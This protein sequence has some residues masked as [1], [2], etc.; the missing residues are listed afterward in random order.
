M[1]II[2][3]VQFGQDTFSKKL[4]EFFQYNHH[5]IAVYMML[6][7]A[8]QCITLKVLVEKDKNRVVFVES[9]KDFVD[10]LF[11]FMTMPIGNIIRLAREHSIEENFGCLNNL[12]ESVENLDKEHLRSVKCKDMLLRPR[13]AAEIYCR[14]LKLNFVDTNDFYACCVKYNSYN[15]NCIC[16]GPY[17]NAR[18]R[19]GLTI[20]TLHKLDNHPSIHQGGVF[21]K[22]T[23]RFI[24]TDD[25]QVKP[26]STTTCVALLN[27]FK[28]TDR[29][30]REERTINIGMEK[31]INKYSFTF[32]IF[33]CTK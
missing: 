10:V 18:Y 7:D 9:N 23:A 8:S 1:G 17:L 12:N 27:E 32:L 26:I 6:N 11:S 31:V 16:F 14:N 19:C 21:V 13:S 20:R 3:A 29:S 33:P 5:H 22:P 28:A 15:P 25:F 30:T 2:N 4:A 24:I